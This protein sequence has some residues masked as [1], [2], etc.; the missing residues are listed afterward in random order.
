[1]NIKS[2]LKQFRLKANFTQEEL[3]V[4]LNVTRQT[5]NAIEQ[6]K[7]QPS[8]LLAYQCSKLFGV[9]IENIFY[10]E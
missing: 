2:N 5:I 6:A 9:P 3:A 1:M 10:F 4:K 8:L 7:Y